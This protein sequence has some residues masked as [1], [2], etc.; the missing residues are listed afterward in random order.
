MHLGGQSLALNP[1]A[2][3]AYDASLRYFYRK[4][5]GS[6]AGLMLRMLLPVYSRMRS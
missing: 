4:H 1:K 2:R 3:R 6:V 5:Y